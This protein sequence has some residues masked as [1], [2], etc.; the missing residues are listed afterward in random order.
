MRLYKYCS[1]DLLDRVLTVDAKVRLKFS[2]PKN[3]NDPLELFLTLRGEE[4]DPRVI[5]YYM[6]ILGDI[7]QLPT[8]CFSMRPDVIPMWAHYG[9]EHVGFAIEID[10]ETLCDN[11]S[12]GYVEDVEYVDET[13]TAEWGSIRFAATTKKFRHTYFAQTA[14]FKSA[15]FTKNRCWA[16][17]LERRLV[18]DPKL[19]PDD[20][21]LM[22]RVLSPRR[23][24]MSDKT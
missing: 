16:Y 17:E 13:G 9:A 24:A 7:P 21:P 18:V 5:A 2:H 14:A 23:V 8:T 12:I 19:F 10:E 4:R 3:Y 6:T 11:I 1:P 15:Y 22:K 20:N